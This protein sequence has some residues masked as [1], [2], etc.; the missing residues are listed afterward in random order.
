[1]FVPYPPSFLWNTIAGNHRRSDTRAHKGLGPR[2][3]TA[4]SYPRYREDLPRLGP[5][6]GQKIPG[7]GRADCRLVDLPRWPRAD[8]CAN[9]A[10]KQQVRTNGVGASRIVG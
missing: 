7:E 9:R 2:T 6:R 10:G 8:R 5:W 1:M 3:L 4:V